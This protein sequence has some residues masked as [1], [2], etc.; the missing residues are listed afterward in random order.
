MLAVTS[1]DA[2]VDVRLGVSVT[3]IDRDDCSVG[4][5]EGDVLRADVVVA[6]VGGS[7]GL[8]TAV[9]ANDKHLL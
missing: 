1:I 8:R 2:G 5:S 6:A 4:L 3:S 7:S 9:S